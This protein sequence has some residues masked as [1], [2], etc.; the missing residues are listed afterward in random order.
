KGKAEGDLTSAPATWTRA[1]PAWLAVAPPPVAVDRGRGRRKKGGARPAVAPDVAC[2]GR[3][4]RRPQP[5]PP[6]PLSP[7]LVCTVAALMLLLNRTAAPLPP[8]LVCT[9]AALPLLLDGTTAALPLLLV[10]RCRPTAANAPVAVATLLCRCGCYPQE[11]PPPSKGGGR[12]R[13]PRDPPSLA[14]FHAE[15][16]WE[17]GQTK[18][19]KKNRKKK[20]REGPMCKMPKMQDLRGKYTHAP[21]LVPPP[22]T[23]KGG[24]VPKPKEEIF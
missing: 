12:K 14:L 22:P 8:L 16:D 7:L 17:G 2:T 13:G 1:A 11:R 24:G 21:D 9:A 19:K 23:I 6:R 5:A 18:M 10:Y 3:R 4:C 15:A 20:K